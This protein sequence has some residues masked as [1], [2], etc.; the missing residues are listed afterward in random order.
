M[1]LVIDVGNTETVFGIYQNEELIAYWRLS[2]KNQRTADECW[3]ILKMWCETQSLSILDIN[4]IVISSVVPLLASI[5]KEMSVRY[6]KLEPLIVSSSTNTGIEI[7]YDT[8]RTVGADRICNAVAGFSHFGGPLIVVDFGTATTFDVISKNGK[9]LGGVI[10][11]G[12]KGA[13]EELHRI[14]AKLPRVDLEFP[15][16]VVGKTTETSMQSGI[17]W[18]TVALIDGMVE[19]IMNEMKWKNPKIIATGGIAPV[20]IEKSER[21]EHVE[22]HLTLEG[23]RL[24]YKRYSKKSK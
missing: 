10:A 6:L 20:L 22:P 5:F 14:S 4:G 3:I 2:S 21:I 1:L 15:A 12:L 16:F 13:S 9:Y 17:L 19:K 8:P 11:L 23:M 7:L 18:G 24:I